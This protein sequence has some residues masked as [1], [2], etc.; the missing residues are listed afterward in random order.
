MRSSEVHAPHTPDVHVSDAR[1]TDA[2]APDDRPSDV[3]VVGG[4]VIGLVTAWRAA[5]RGLRT[6]V[7]DPGPGGGAA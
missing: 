1:A 2:R 6:A 5:R 7:V 4:G 3:L